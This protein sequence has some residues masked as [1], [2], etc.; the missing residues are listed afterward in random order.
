MNMKRFIPLKVRR[1]NPLRF[2]STMLPVTGL[3]VYLA[4]Y[5]IFRSEKGKGYRK[6]NIDGK[7]EKGKKNE[8]TLCWGADVERKHRKKS[9]PRTGF[10]LGLVF[11]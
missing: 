9:I 11:F 10:Q 4:R 3:C 8:T 6:W 7:G 2:R 1:G 5:P